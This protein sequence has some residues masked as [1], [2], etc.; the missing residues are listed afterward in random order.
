MELILNLEEIYFRFQMKVIDNSYSYGDGDPYF[1]N[2]KEFH[3]EVFVSDS[4]HYNFCGV[5]G[6]SDATSLMNLSEQ[7]CQGKLTESEQYL[8]DGIEENSAFQVEFNPQS[9]YAYLKIFF[10]NRNDELTE[11]GITLALTDED[12]VL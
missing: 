7:F 8:V 3:G 9:L 2:L 1:D 11:Q 10:Y 12:C 6:W 4:L 5:W